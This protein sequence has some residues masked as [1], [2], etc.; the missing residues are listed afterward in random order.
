VNVSLLVLVFNIHHDHI[1]SN[2]KERFVVNHV[3]KQAPPGLPTA[4]THTIDK[5]CHSHQQYWMMNVGDDKGAI[6]D[7]LIQQQVRT[8]VSSRLA[9]RKE[10]PIIM[11][12]I[13]GYIGYSAIRFS[14]QLNRVAQE[15]YHK[16]GLKW[17]PPQYISYEV[18]LE[19]VELARKVIM[20]FSHRTKY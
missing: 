19:R 4:I 8:L 6:V 5:L 7:N 16:A 17:V 14:H 18:D 15:E 9:N 11:V 12:E 1:G 20:T 13:G 2:E 3:L 10:A